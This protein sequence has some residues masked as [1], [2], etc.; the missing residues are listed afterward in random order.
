MSL[1]RR[2]AVVGLALAALTTLA[3][4]ALAAVPCQETP[5]LG[6]ESPGQS[7]QS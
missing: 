3:A 1:V 6:P 5:A 2:L 4:I 7:R